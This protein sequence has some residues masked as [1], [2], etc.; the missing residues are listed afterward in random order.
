MREPDFR[1]FLVTE[2]TFHAAYL[3]TRWLETFAG[4]AQFRGLVV[5]EPDGCAATPT[6]REAF[7]RD[8]AGDRRLAPAAH[9]RLRELYPGLSR[10]DESMLALFGV[11]A[12][13]ST[14]APDTVC[15]GRTLNSDRARRWLVDTCAATAPF[16]F[17]FLDELLADWWIEL[18]ES[19]IINGHSAV[20]PYA[21][22]MFA[23]ENVAASGDRER[24]ER[25][26]GATV[27]Y[28]DR[29]IDTG[30]IIRA[31]RLTGRWLES[32]WHQKATVFMLVFE[33]LIRVAAD[34]VARPHLL[35]VGTPPDVAVRGPN[36][37]RRD[38]TPE[39][40]RRAEEGYLSIRARALGDEDP[41]HRLFDRPRRDP[42]AM[43]RGRDG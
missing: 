41:D 14:G 20:L 26:L 10:T 7:H 42:I 36:F 3:V 40:R 37:N 31:E 1:F 5:R 27:H 12:H 9:E 30:P 19:R 4:V 34:L 11:P 24:F 13:S 16:F 32:I 21:R 8:H 15:L 2:P 43:A 39:T 17:V 29:G 28:I 38:F 35:P 33:L 23:I 18:S 25:A 22:G 6:A